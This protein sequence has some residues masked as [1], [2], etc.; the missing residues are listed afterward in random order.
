MSIIIGAPI[1]GISI[2]GLEYLLDP[3]NNVAVFKD[4]G[5]AKQTLRNLG[6]K[7]QEVEDYF[8]YVDA[9]SDDK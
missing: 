6:Y 9:G 1:N 8:T 7:D 2:N 3:D 4:V 5:E